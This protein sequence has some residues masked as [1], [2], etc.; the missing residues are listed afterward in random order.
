[1]IFSFSAF[2]LLKTEHTLRWLQPLV[3]PWQCGFERVPCHWIPSFN[4]PP[5]CHF[6]SSPFLLAPPPFSLSCG[7][8]CL[9]RIPVIHLAHIKHLLWASQGAWWQ[10]ICLQWG[11]PGFDSW[12]GKI[13]WKRAWQPTPI[14]LPGESHGQRRLVGCS[15]W[16]SRESDTTEET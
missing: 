1:M 12:V 7:R 8:R 13:P 11:K 2:E 16:G 10:R 6:N 3:T 5:S 14:S 4:H 15:P 9:L